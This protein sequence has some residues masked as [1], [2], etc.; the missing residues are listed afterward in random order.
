MTI[1]EQYKHDVEY[2]AQHP[3]FVDEQDDLFGSPS[4]GCYQQFSE[5]ENGED[6]IRFVFDNGNVYGINQETEALEFKETLP[7]YV[8]IHLHLQNLI[9]EFRIQK[10]L[11]LSEAS[12]V[13]CAANEIISKPFVR[14][15]INREESLIGI[16]N[17]ILNPQYQHQNIGKDFLKKVFALCKQFNFRLILLDCMPTFYS[18]MVARGATILVEGDHLKITDATDL[19]NHH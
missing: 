11:S 16:T 17:F 1:E 4:Q 14:I 13:I 6:V 2:N 8:F 19:D 9:N 10:S 3:K 15:I 18:R 5:N 7:Q 12:D